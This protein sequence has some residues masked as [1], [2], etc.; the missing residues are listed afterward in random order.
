MEYDFTVTDDRDNHYVPQ[1]L[2]EGWCNADGKLTVYSRRHGRV[3]ASELKPRSTAF[4]TNLYAYHA[5]PPEKRHAIENEFMSPKIDAPAA[6]IVEKILKGRFTELTIDERSDFTR[7]VLSLRARHPDAVAIAR[8]HGTEALTAA[9][10]RDP[11]EYLAVRDESSPDS[12]TAWTRQKAPSLIMNFGLSVMPAVIVDSKTGERVFKMPWWTHDVSGAN[13]DLLLSDRPCI[14]EGNALDG[15]CVIAL[16]LSSRMLFF[17][18]NRPAQ[19]Q[20]LRAMPV[21][22]LVKM[23][24]KASVTYASDRVYATGKH[25]L[26]L[27]EKYLKARVSAV[28][29]SATCA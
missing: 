11:E 25:H 12:L 3:V 20:F 13:V 26:P 5:V 28:A 23:M 6:L 21:T 9:L 4:E 2:L 1:F 14:L 27:V 29:E 19:T 15:D 7:F 24:N 16:P 10:A 17:I 22:S 8:A 18:C